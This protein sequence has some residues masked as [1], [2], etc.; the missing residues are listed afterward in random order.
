MNTK[1]IIRLINNERMGR[2]KISV[3]ACDATSND[4]CAVED[5]AACTVYSYDLCVKDYAGCKNY[6][7]DYCSGPNGE[8]TVA[9][10]APNSS[11]I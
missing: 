6:S 9:C 8:D 5:N 3:K 1:R 4:V 7:V 10:I 11:D 2:N